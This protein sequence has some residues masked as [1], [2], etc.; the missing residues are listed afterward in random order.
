[1]QVGFVS[2]SVIVTPTLKGVL[3]VR[4]IGFPSLPFHSFIVLMEKLGETRKCSEMNSSCVL[5]IIATGH[6]YC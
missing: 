1:M 6:D 2:R 3:S 4:I 5:E